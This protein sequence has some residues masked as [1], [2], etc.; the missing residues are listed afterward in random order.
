[1]HNGI[2]PLYLTQ[3]TSSYNTT[4]TSDSYR[5]SSPSPTSQNEK[6]PA[7]PSKKISNRT[8]VEDIEKLTAD[9]TL[10]S[11]VIN[12]ASLK[13]FILFKARNLNKTNQTRLEKLQGEAQALLNAINESPT[14]QLQNLKIAKA[15]EPGDDLLSDLPCEIQMLITSYLSFKDLHSL[16]GASKYWNYY[17]HHLA[18]IELPI[19]QVGE[20]IALKLSDF[21]PKLT[22]FGL[23][24]MLNSATGNHFSWFKLNKLRKKKDQ[25]KTIDYDTLVKI[26][27]EY[28]S[29]KIK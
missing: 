8:F 12:I 25:P 17:Y 16:K 27:K 9:S 1:M 5:K 26:T 21:Q 19:I 22:H 7:K 10:Y 4:H 13:E 24:K 23:H 18:S 3:P 28:T 6:S 29:L 20:Q 2:F 14:Y 15:C 11:S